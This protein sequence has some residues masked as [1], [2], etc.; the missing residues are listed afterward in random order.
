MDI[1]F[2]TYTNYVMPCG[3]MVKS[4]CCNNRDEEI[5]FHAVIDETVT[6]SDKAS[7]LGVLD[8]ERGKSIV[9]HLFDDP[10]VDSFPIRWKKTYNKSVYYRLFFPDLLPDVDKLIFLDGDIIVR[11]SLRPLYELDISD[12]AIAAVPDMNES[13]MS[14]YNRLQYPSSKGYFNAGVELLNLSFWRRN[15]IKE[16]C[17]DY[18]FRFPERIWLNDQDVMNIILKDCK[19]VLDLKFNLQDGMLWKEPDFF[20]FAK[21]GKELEDAVSDPVVLH[22][23]NS[24][25]WF[26]GC[27]HPYVDEFVKYQDMTEWKGVLL[28]RRMSLKDYLKR[29]LFIFLKII[30]RNP[31]NI[32]RDVALKESFSQ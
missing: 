10:E 18:L 21:Y 27:L 29:Q 6:Q 8:G 30:P 24:K 2:C 16:K 31:V 7:L 15:K 12:L 19:K 23:T 11:H 26:K 28:K 1:A 25:P 32:Y 5:I 13:K 14:F 4:V 9:F 17:V 3:V 20:E 22:F